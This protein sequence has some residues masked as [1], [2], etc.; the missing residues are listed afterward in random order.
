MNG[1]SSRRGQLRR[2]TMPHMRKAWV[3]AVL[4]VALVV[5]CGSSGPAHGPT[6]GEGAAAY[7]GAPADS[8]S[9]SKDQLRA[10][11]RDIDAKLGCPDA[12]VTSGGG[13]STG[14]QTSNCEGISV[15]E[16]FPSMYYDVFVFPTAQ[17]RDEFASKSLDFGHTYDAK[18]TTK[19]GLAWLVSAGT[20]EAGLKFVLGV[21][22]GEPV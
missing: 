17:A 7:T 8:G 13:L 9:A 16:M 2:A 18:G 4:P 1:R 10:A 15:E 12:L 20:E 11:V 19:D 21:V 5:G 6:S 3:L 22:G 14:A